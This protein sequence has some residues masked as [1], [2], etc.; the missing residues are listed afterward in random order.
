MHGHAKAFCHPKDSIMLSKHWC[1]GQV[2]TWHSAAAHCLRIHTLVLTVA[3]LTFVCATSCAQVSGH[4]THHIVHDIK[5]PELSRKLTS[6]STALVLYKG[7]TIFCMHLICNKGTTGA[8]QKLTLVN[9]LFALIC[10][11]TALM[12]RTSCAQQSTDSWACIRQ[13]MVGHTETQFGNFLAHFL[14]YLLRINRAWCPISSLLPFCV[15]GPIAFLSISKTFFFSIIAFECAGYGIQHHPCHP[16]GRAVPIPLNSML[17]F[18]M[19]PLL[20]AQG[21]AFGIIP[22]FFVGGA[23]AFLRQA[24]FFKK[25][26]RFKDFRHDVKSRLIAKCV[27]CLSSASSHVGSAKPV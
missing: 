1:V 25:G 24:Y 9:A 10:N 21:M 17:P 13:G 15:G 18:S 20:H 3:P 2:V 12:E 23:I 5:D 22:A 11:N 26:L 16:C 8:S 6:V 27:L 4:L 19:I 7:N 14:C